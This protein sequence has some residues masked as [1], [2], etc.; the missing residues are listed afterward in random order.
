M[1]NTVTRLMELADRYAANYRAHYTPAGCENVNI[2]D[3][4]QALEAELTRLFTPLSD[5]QIESGRKDMFS[6]GN[7]FCPCDRKTMR[8]AVQWAE[9]Q[10]SIGGE[11]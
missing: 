9:R 10:H 11:S 4:R 3:A 8:K 1:T 7:P 5:E 2:T 6:T